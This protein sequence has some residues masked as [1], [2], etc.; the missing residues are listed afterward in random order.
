MARKAAVVAVV[1]LL[2]IGFSSQGWAA[3]AAS[4]MDSSAGAA[5]GSTDSSS[6][7]QK[8]DTVAPGEPTAKATIYCIG[9]MW[10]VEGDANGSATCAVSFREVG[11]D[12][13]QE[14]LS[15]YRKAPAAM[16]QR[17]RPGGNRPSATQDRLIDSTR[18]AF[19]AS[20]SIESTQP[21]AAQARPT[22]AQR[23]Q[24]QDDGTDRYMKDHY[25]ANY[26]AGSIFSLKPATAYEV[27][28]KL[29][30]SDGGASVEK[31]LKAKTRMEPLLPTEG[32]KVDVAAEGGATALAAA[33]ESAKPG[34]I[35]TIH[36]GTYVGPFKIAASGT[37]DKPIVIR[38]AG[39]GPAI[40]T[41]LGYE[42]TE[43]GESSHICL[44]VDGS[45]IF[46]H[47]LGFS[48]AVAAIS[49]GGGRF[50]QKDRFDK[51]RAS[52]G[53]LSNVVVTRC[54]T[55][56]TQYGVVGTADDCF[57]AD[58]DFN[59]LAADVEGIDWSEGEGV[60]IHGS[61]T[62][63][64]YN[65]MYH[66]ADVVSVYDFTDNQD[67]YNN[68]SYSNS[69]DGIELDYSDAN[70]RV[71]D[72]RFW[73][74]ANN[75]VSFQPYIGGPVYIIR[76]EVIGPKENSSKDRNGSRDAFFF[77]NTFI[78]HKADRSIGR[79][80][81]LSSFDM[82][83]HSVSRNNLYIIQ[84]ADLPAVDV[85]IE[86]VTN[87]TLDMDYDGLSGM[88]ILKDRNGGKDADPTMFPGSRYVDGDGLYVPIDSMRK[89]TRTLEHYSVVDPAKIFE[90]PLPAN[91][92][93][94]VETERN[95][96]LLREGCNAIDAGVAI[97]TVTDG[98]LGKAP[99]LGA[100]EFGKPAPHYGPRPQ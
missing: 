10:P 76:N 84:D 36:K 86:D 37:A 94:R 6:A 89:A 51:L 45:H 19:G 40:L 13:W 78:G 38:G 14:A 24:V 52:G 7:P 85:H 27:R 83:L 70:N 28:L 96:M 3:E 72:N 74:P 47:A 100:H 12:K 18:A 42:K 92:E 44:R 5:I 54:R 17:R 95:L 67:V 48:D 53:V 91:H 55:E 88:F 46:I 99:D 49:I 57:V 82:P 63:V 87:H 66:L 33:F 25:A 23:P 65:R 30:D 9:V 21:S 41:G 20:R 71:W 50:T 68:D 39:D 90:K 79:N 56:K 80:C 59:G 64:C 22:G 8:P 98:F 34:D 35:I 29:T 11:T 77:N 62:I 61:G 1:M 32:H 58:N 75:G 4:S 26:L 16:P 2:A 81:Y 97:P 43:E 31:T 60:E 93:W 69:D 15:L 73:F